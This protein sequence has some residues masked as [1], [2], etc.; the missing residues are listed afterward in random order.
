MG[1][2]IWPLV[3]AVGGAGLVGAGW[4]INRAPEVD[5]QPPVKT[6]SMAQPDPEVAPKSPDPVQ[7]APV[8]PATPEPADPVAETPEKVEEVEQAE[9]GP[10]LD[11]IRV[12]PDGLAVFAGRA[13]PGADLVFRLDGMQVA[14][15]KADLTG[16]FATVAMLDPSDTARVLTLVE[17]IS[18]GTEK[19]APDEI[20]LAPIIAA[21]AAPLPEV[22]PPVVA[23]VTQPAAPEVPGQE[24]QLALATDAASPGA[25]NAPAPLAVPDAGQSVQADTRPTTPAAPAPVVA[26]PSAPVTVAPPQPE[27][28]APQPE[29]AQSRADDAT[30]APQRLAILKSDA[31]GVVVVRNASE[32][33]PEV[34]EIALDT[35]SYSEAGEVELAGRAGLRAQRV[36]VYL[37]NRVIAAIPVDPGGG[38]R[39]ELPDV[40]TG[41]Y[42]LRVD[43]VD[44][45][46]NVTS[47]VET[48][49]K[50]E[51]PVVLAATTAPGAAPVRAVTVQKGA[52]LWAIARDRYGEGTLY[53]RV[54]EANKD[55]IRDPDLI[56]PGQVF[57]LP[58]D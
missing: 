19:L 8:E 56:Y 7:A 27:I 42:T 52:T 49:F 2:K 11:E 25:V 39:G 16:S 32:R 29:T 18:D 33:A 55:L 13:R 43:E 31:D 4:Y 3:I 46:G 48:P 53:V 6:V 9:P 40:D 41:L 10:V 35:I 14:T 23:A 37:N 1:L 47:R 38:W 24:R 21:P 22:E 54:F 20:I 34:T 58:E 28:A 36:Q 15:A 17:L 12:E 26:S 50:R 45:A 5:Q 44:T 57:S 51:D 30:P